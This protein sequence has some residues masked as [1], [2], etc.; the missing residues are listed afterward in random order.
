MKTHATVLAAAALLT[1]APA[2]ADK[3]ARDADGCSDKIVTRMR[4]C[5]I[6]MCQ[7]K[8]FFAEPMRTGKSSEEKPEGAYEE[9]VYF[10]DS[11]TTFIEISR[12]LEAGLKAAGYKVRYKF[13][14]SNGSTVTAQKND[15][16]VK[17]DCRTGE[18]VLK[19]IK[20]KQLEQ[21]VEPTVDGWTQAIEQTGRVSIYGINFDTGQATLRAE[22]E[23]VLEEVAQLLK[24]NL[25]WRV[26]IVGHTDN[27]GSA[28]INLPLSRQRAESVIGWL[29]A[30]GVGKDRL[31]PGGF[32]S[33]VPIADNG[34]DE[35]RAKNR[36]VDVIK[37]Y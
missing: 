5:G 23:K 35:G 19:A 30:H 13:D 26:A 14:G 9:I 6:Y 18:Y 24:K 16:W 25:A 20:V 17:A 12:N 1:G 31:L 34:T 36:R 29:G 7:S 8:D 21:V 15:Q 33:L 3:P 27:T 28:E 32:G 37:L 22:S 2:L 10:C 11:K 4:G